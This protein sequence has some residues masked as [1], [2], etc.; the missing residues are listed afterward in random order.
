MCQFGEILPWFYRF[1]ATLILKHRENGR[2]R[3]DML[4]HVMRILFSI[5]IEML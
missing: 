4:F 2:R 5:C 1:N 3:R